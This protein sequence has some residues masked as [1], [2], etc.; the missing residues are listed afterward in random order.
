M[1][2]GVYD[3]TAGGNLKDYEIRYM[4]LIVAPV[5]EE[6]FSEMATSVEIQNEGAG[7]FVV[8]SQTG[9]NDI[10]KIA[11]SPEEWGKIRD[12]IDMQIAQCRGQNV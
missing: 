3:S 1:N 8:V 9:R 2:Y 11:I 4:K 5:G 12:A 7:E 10:G 6:I